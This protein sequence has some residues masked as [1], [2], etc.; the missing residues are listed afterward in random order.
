[1]ATWKI[2][3]ML[4]KPQEAGYTDVV[5]QIFW[6][7]TDSDGMYEA[8]QA[9]KTE[10]G[11]PASGFTPYDQL[12]EAQV[13]GWVQTSLGP[14]EVAAIEQNLNLQIVYM[15]APPVIALPLPW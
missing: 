7:V 2:D 3:S 1:M 5:Y 14:E 12:T 15:Q 9:G 13:L 10:V 4:I 6:T 8:G 11:L